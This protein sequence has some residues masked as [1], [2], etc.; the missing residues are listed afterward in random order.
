MN[1][2]Y[3]TR[4]FSDWLAR[5]PNKKGQARILDRIRSARD[6]NFG[7]CK[8]LGGGVSEM[9][10]H[11]GPGYRVYFAREGERIYLL[12]LGGDKSGQKRDIQ[13]A[14]ELWKKIREDDE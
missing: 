1:S 6:G 4:L 5:L 7:D 12:L 10:V 8:A 11:F 2:I 9:R 13:R 14:K 3:E